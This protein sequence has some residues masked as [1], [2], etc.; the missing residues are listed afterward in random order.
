MKPRTLRA[1]TNQTLCFEELTL[2]EDRGVGKSMVF[3]SSES[4]LNSSI[5]PKFS[6]AGEFELKKP[7]FG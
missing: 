4:M 1:T 3:F 2:T 5:E 6:V 7:S